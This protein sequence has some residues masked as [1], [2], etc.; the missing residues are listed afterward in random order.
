MERHI[1]SDISPAAGDGGEALP[2]TILGHVLKGWHKH[3]TIVL[4]SSLVF[5]FG[6]VSFGIIMVVMTFFLAIILGIV[7]E[8]KRNFWGVCLI[9]IVVGYVVMTGFGY[10]LFAM[11][12]K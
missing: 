6:H 2:H 11:M 10:Q 1:L 3:I 9:H 8:F 4:I 7:F 5:A 12:P